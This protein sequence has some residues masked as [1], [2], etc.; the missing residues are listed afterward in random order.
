MNATVKLVLEKTLGP[1]PDAKNWGGILGYIEEHNPDL[2]VELWLLDRATSGLLFRDPNHTLSWNIATRA[3]AGDPLAI[4]LCKAL[5][6]LSP[7][8]CERVLD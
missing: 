3:R 2:Y 1:A 6:A 8:H 5:N 7:A 4:E